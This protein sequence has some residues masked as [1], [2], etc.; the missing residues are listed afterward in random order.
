MASEMIARLN[1]R[2]EYFHGTPQAWQ[3]NSDRTH[4][5]RR[6]PFVRCGRLKGR[7]LLRKEEAESQVSTRLGRIQASVGS[8]SADLTRS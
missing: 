5:P 2:G 1:Y 6:H 3:R 8:A 4:F 7:I